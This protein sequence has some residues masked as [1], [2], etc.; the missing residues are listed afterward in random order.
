MQEKADGGGEFVRVV[1]RPRVTIAKVC[2]RARA[3]T[4]HEKAH[5]LCFI[6]RSVRSPVD[7]APQ[8]AD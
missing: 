8:I 6:E 4:L 3:L 2:D 7:I 5:H 1:P